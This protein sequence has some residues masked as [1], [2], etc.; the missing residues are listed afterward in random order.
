MPAPFDL[1]LFPIAQRLEQLEG[2]LERY[3]PLKRHP[4]GSSSTMLS[5]M[6][7]RG[8]YEL[9]SRRTRLTGPVVPAK[10]PIFLAL[11]KFM[12]KVRRVFRFLCQ[13]HQLMTSCLVRY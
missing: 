9:F 12:L 7:D 13:F 10:Q 3:Y 11:I 2:L 6:H 8:A 5:G 1:C 4:G